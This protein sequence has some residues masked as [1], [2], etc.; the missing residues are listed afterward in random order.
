MDRLSSH[1]GYARSEWLGDRHLA[2]ARNEYLLDHSR[3]LL[4]YA[5]LLFERRD[6]AERATELLALEK[7]LVSFA[8]NSN[9]QHSLLGDSPQ[10]Q[11]ERSVSLAMTLE[12]L[13]MQPLPGVDLHARHVE[14]LQQ[15]EELHRHCIYVRQEYPETFADR[16]L[17][18]AVTLL[19]ARI[20]IA[21]SLPRRAYLLLKEGEVMLR[22]VADLRQKAGLYRQLAQLYGRTGHPVRGWLSARKARGIQRQLNNT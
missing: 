2:T 14:L 22:D 16:A 13:D 1:E 17:A 19:L 3:G 10:E 9:Y 12:W 5:G 4:R 7:E 6:D 20:L 11:V 8:R 15:S 21:R 18:C